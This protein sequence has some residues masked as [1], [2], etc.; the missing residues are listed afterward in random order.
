[1][2]TP[3]GGLLELLAGVLL[4]EQ[5]GALRPAHL[6]VERATVELDEAHDLRTLVAISGSRDY[7]KMGSDLR[8]VESSRKGNLHKLSN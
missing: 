3:L 6:A 2:K 5:V 7:L 4:R 8:V 1:M